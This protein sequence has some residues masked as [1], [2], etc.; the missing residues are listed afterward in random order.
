MPKNTPE[1]LPNDVASISVDSLVKMLNLREN[2]F[3]WLF[4]LVTYSVTL[5]S[6]CCLE[7]TFDNWCRVTRRTWGNFCCNKNRDNLSSV[8]TSI[9]HVLLIQCYWM[10]SL[11][12]LGKRR[13]TPGHIASLLQG[14]HRS[15]QSF[16][17][18]FTTMANLKLLLNL[19]SMFLDW[20]RAWRCRTCTCMKGS[21][22]PVNLN[23]GP[24]CTTVPPLHLLITG[25]FFFL[26]LFCFL[27]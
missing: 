12:S 2:V 6:L 10:L 25:Y 14:S 8:C 13:C 27:Q 3:T 26:N 9:H 1:V 22:R 18:I 16:T 15:R 24:F 7:S 21:C 11:L 4:S 17:P 20:R 19:T 23:S 5:K